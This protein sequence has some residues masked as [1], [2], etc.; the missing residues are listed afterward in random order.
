[1]N[2]VSDI[3]FNDFSLEK[4]VIVNEQ[5]KAV[6]ADTGKQE[7]FPRMT[8]LMSGYGFKRDAGQRTMS[9]QELSEGV[10]SALNKPKPQYTPNPK[11]LNPD[12]KSHKGLQDLVIKL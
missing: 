4:R 10:D 5:G 11:I 7:M 9:D 3:L 2:T 8:N 12:P 1:M 6:H